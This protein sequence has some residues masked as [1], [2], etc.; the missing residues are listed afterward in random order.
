MAT[1]NCRRKPMMTSVAVNGMD[2]VDGTGRN[3]AGS[4]AKLVDEWVE[5]TETV[6]SGAGSLRSV[7]PSDMVH[8]KSG[9]YEPTLSFLPA[10]AGGKYQA[11]RGGDLAA[12][13]AETRRCLS[14]S[15]AWCWFQKEAELAGAALLGT[16]STVVVDKLRAHVSAVTSKMDAGVVG[17]GAVTH[18]GKMYTGAAHSRA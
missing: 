5:S 12:F 1:N 4:V 2:W 3:A 10:A 8:G 9:A 11:R 16:K 13:A 6:C 7:S 17:A 15:G 14:R 18:S